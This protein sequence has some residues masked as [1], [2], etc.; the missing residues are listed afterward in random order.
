[1]KA[2]KLISVFIP[3]LLSLS[4]FVFV[5][6]W[7]STN[8]KNIKLVINANLTSDS[9]NKLVYKSLGIKLYP[10]VAWWA[11]QQKVEF[12]KKIIVSVRPN[13]NAWNLLKLIKNYKVT[14]FDWVL[15]SSGTLKEVIDDVVYDYQQN[16]QNFRWV[17]SSVASWFLQDSVY[18]SYG[19]TSQTAHCLF[20]ANTYNL[21]ANY[22]PREFLDRMFLESYKKY[23]N[24]KRRTAAQNRK[25]S[26]EQIIILASIVTKE[27]N[28]TVEF[29]KIA[30]VYKL[31]LI[32]DMRLE[33]DP[34]VVFAR[35]KSGRVLL[36]DTKINSPYNTYLNKGLPPGPL[37]I[38][39]P[40][41]IDSVLFGTEYPF[42]FF[43]AKPD[44]SGTHNFA[45][46]LSEHQANAK[47]YH[48]W[49]NQRK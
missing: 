48:N 27:S 46:N 40:K 32:K 12:N 18:H 6:Q 22:S 44:H 45:I 14:N 21:K 23:W 33:A 10:G 49:L 5:Q 19:L 25:L 13:T 39:D 1:V 3:V 2:R 41:A 16:T 30:S 37:C 20:I 26:L 24:Y 31:R 29:G 42:L 4:L 36:S 15:R 35:G 9:I 43:C 8:T 38:P 47:A 11:Q 28:A 34:T 7:K 17:N